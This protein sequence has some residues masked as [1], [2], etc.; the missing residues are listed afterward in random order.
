[1]DERDAGTVGDGAEDVE[2]SFEERQSPA[3]PEA[4][5]D[6]KPVNVDVAEE[7][8]DRGFGGPNDEGLRTRG[9]AVV[10]PRVAEALRYAGA[11]LRG[12]VCESAG[13]TGVPY[14]RYVKWFGA[15]LPPSPWCAFFVSWCWDNATDRNHRTP[16]SNPGYVPSVR[17][18]AR[19]H[20]KTVSRPRQGDVFGIDGAHMGWV[21]RTEGSAIMTIEG[22]TS[23]G[24]VASHRRSPSGLWFARIA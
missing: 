24:C 6:A 9:R 5:A 11:E 14:T 20:G 4:F 3:P 7:R 10:D 15:G 23:S 13:N 2:P 8:E 17:E 1:M 16:W 18:W 22:N 21:L 19:A 12:R